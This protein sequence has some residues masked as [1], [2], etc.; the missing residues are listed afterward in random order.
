MCYNALESLRN[1]MGR[2]ISIKFQFS[3]VEVDFSVVAV[4]G[5]CR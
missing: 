5:Q 2:P 4:T 1:L 3:D